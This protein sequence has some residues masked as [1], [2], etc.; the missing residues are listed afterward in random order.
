[1]SSFSYSC[2]GKNAEEDRCGKTLQR[3][4]S[5]SRRGNKLSETRA[6]SPP[7]SSSSASFRPFVTTADHILILPLKT[8]LGGVWLKFIISF[9]LSF[10][11][12]SFI[13]PPCFCRPCEVPSLLRFWFPLTTL[14]AIFYFVTSPPRQD[15]LC[16][17]V[18]L[19]CPLCRLSPQLHG[20]NAASASPD[21]LLHLRRPPSILLSSSQ[22]C[23]FSEEL[24]SSA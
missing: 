12:L 13:P 6:H 16:F 8:L 4:R 9:C 11:S 20:F 10:I 19:S 24:C 7:S 2:K 21:S 3:L 1:M 18:V 17:N 15:F 5:T 23:P 22:A 14:R